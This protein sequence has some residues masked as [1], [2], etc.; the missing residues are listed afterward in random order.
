[1]KINMLNEDDQIYICTTHLS[2]PRTIL[3]SYLLAK[4]LSH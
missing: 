2:P 3:P 1:M 4:G